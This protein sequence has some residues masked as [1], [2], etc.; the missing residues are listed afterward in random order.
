MLIPS[1]DISRGRAV[2]LRQGKDLVVTSDRD[3]RDLA[4]EFSRVGEIA[5]V[6]LDAALGTGDNIELVEAICAVAPCRVGGGIRDVER[7]RRLLRAGAHK[8]IIGTKAAPEFLSQLPASRLMAAVD[9]REDKVVDHGWTFVLEESPIERAKRLAPYVSGFLYTIVEREGTEG[10]L[11]LARVRAMAEAVDLPITAAG[12]VTTTDEILTLDR[13]GVDTQVGMALYKGYLKPSECLAAVVDFK[14]NGDACV[15][16]VQDALDGRLLMVAR[17][18]RETLIEA[19]E[20][21][22][23]VLYSRRRGRWRKGEESGNTQRLVR[24]EVDC[25]RDT[26]LFLVEPRGPACHKG[27]ASCFGDRW[28]SLQWLE[29]T[30]QSRR[31]APGDQSY[32]RRLLDDAALRRGKIMEEAQE[33]IEAG[34]RDHARWEAADLFYHTMVEMQARGLTLADIVAELAARH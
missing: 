17:S 6:D 2:Q 16:V 30:I 9:A 10:G 1:I 15:T 28:F 31:T 23:T 8:L 11:D 14:K 12:G 26:L 20:T 22:E 19:I 13:L 18:N 5:V 34:T 3:P 24:V 21:G 33:L 29:A 7:A 25:D 4:R 32:T 27:T